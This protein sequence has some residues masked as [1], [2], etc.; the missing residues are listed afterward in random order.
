MTMATAIAMM[1]EK[2]KDNAGG[3]CEERGLPR[4][5]QVTGKEGLQIQEESNETGFS[6][7]QQ[8]SA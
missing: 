8:Y 3:G 5:S 1:M 4:S 6:T 7:R 2:D